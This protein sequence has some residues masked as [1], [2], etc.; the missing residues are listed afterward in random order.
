MR[1]F[2]SLIALL[3]FSMPV[4]AHAGGAALLQEGSAIVG[5]AEPEALIKLA[6]RLH[7][8]ELREYR[9]LRRK[10]GGID[11]LNLELLSPLGLD[12][13][14]VVWF[15]LAAASPKRPALHTRLVLPIRDTDLLFAFIGAL[16]ASGKLALERPDPSSRLGRLGVRL[17][18]GTKESRMVG[19]LERSELVIDVVVNFAGGSPSAL[20]VARSYPLHPT[21]AFSTATGVRSHLEAPSS[22]AAL[23]VAGVPAQMLIEAHARVAMESALA[24]ADPND[25]DKLRAVGLRELEEC[26]AFRA[27]ETMLFDDMAMVLPALPDDPVTHLSF[28]LEWSGK[29]A[30][31]RRRHEGETPLEWVNHLELQ[32]PFATPEAFWR[33]SQQCGYEAQVAM[34]VGAWPLA[35]GTFLKAEGAPLWLRPFS[36]ALAGK[37]LEAKDYLPVIWDTRL[38]PL[39][40]KVRTLEGKTAFEGERLRMTWR[41]TLKP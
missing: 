4:F 12:T 7:V 26:R 15:S 11:P 22:V 23:W 31:R 25:Q 28:E 5:R 36:A 9:A 35:I 24:L 40:E 30:S 29:E 19:R 38:A 39:S 33:L 6:H 21:H 16:S 2:S 14:G 17:T 1:S 18:T 41:A 10:L 3:V 34:L 20:E 27:R 37:P 13:A 32:G 8:E